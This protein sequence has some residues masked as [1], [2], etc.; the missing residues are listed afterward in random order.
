MTMAMGALSF[1]PRIFMPPILKGWSPDQPALEATRRRNVVLDQFF[2]DVGSLTQAEVDWLVQERT[3]AGSV[4]VVFPRD[5]RGDIGIR[6]YPDHATLRA[7]PGPLLT[8]FAV[9]GV[10]CSDLGAAALARNLA[11]HCGQPVGAVVAGYGLSD[12]ISESIGGWFMLGA[13]NRFLGLLYS[14]RDVW[15]ADGTEA[16]TAPAVRSMQDASARSIAGPD[17]DTLLRL[18]QDD[19]RRSTMLLGHSKGCLSIA[20]ALSR[21]SAP[22]PSPAL[23]RARSIRVVTMGAVVEFPAGLDKVAQFLGGLDWFGAMNSRLDR[24]HVA[25]PKAWHHLNTA[26]PMHLD[27]KNVLARA[28]A[29]FAEP[30]V[31]DAGA[32]AQAAQ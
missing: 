31:D 30:P 8:R 11:D 19:D 12:M 17:T 4:L 26:A 22:G 23:D 13:A 3:I 27:V 16:T 25:I 32:P 29:L 21:L 7:T 5:A 6:K 10:G 1:D 28:D 14:M 18:L 15:M 24:G 2:Y 20:A 9:A